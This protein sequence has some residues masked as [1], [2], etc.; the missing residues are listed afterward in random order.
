[1]ES[2]RD[3]V[4]LAAELAARMQHRHDDLKRGLLEL[5]LL[6]DR[7][8]AAVVA[9]RD[10]V[11][12]VNDDFDVRAV[13]GERLVDRVVYDLVDQVVQPLRASGSDV[14]TGALANGLKALENL[15]ILT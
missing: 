2:A 10:A 14:H 11:V 3:L 6:V 8:S 15:D 13:A 12:R 9:D 7:D 4:T 5:G 1:V